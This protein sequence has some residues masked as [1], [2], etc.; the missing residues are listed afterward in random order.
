MSKSL[1]IGSCTFQYPESGT[2]PGWGEEATDWA[3][4]VS[5]KLNTLSGTNDINITSVCIC[6]SASCA[7]IGS[8]GDAFK[9]PTS[10]V[11][12]F[13]ATYNVARTDAC[14]VVT[15]EA[16]TMFGVWNGS[17]WDFSYNFVGCAGMCFSIASCGHVQYSSDACKGSGTIQF[18]A[19]S[20]CQ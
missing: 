18:F 3:V 5:N 17:S 12:S 2:K 11:R 10:A 13:T 20:V 15:V 14:C 1:T 8:G 19:R 6:A 4:A 16:G 7:T 9:F